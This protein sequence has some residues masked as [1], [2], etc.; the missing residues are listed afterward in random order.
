M[1]DISENK[2]Y[3]FEINTNMLEFRGGKNLHGAQGETFSYVTL[4]SSNMYS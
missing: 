3:A 4:I 1:N 2:K